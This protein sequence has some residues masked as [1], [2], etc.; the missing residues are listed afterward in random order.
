MGGMA[1][2]TRKGQRRWRRFGITS[3]LMAGYTLIISLAI[4]AVVLESD[5]TITQ[6]L[7]SSLVA[8]LS[9]EA[10]EFATAASTTRP[11]TENLQAFAT[12][13][14]H[15]H[16]YGRVRLVIMVASASGRPASRLSEPGAA[17]LAHLPTVAKWARV[18]PRHTAT[19]TV[20]TSTGA[21][22]VQGG[23][24]VVAGRRVGTYAAAASVD[25]ISANRSEQRA[26]VAVEGLLALLAAIAGGF[27]LLRRAL[28]T[29]TKVTQA[30]DDARRGDLTQRL[31]YEGPDDEVGRLARTVDAMLS[32]LDASFAAQR[33]LL[34][35]VSHQLRTPL[36]VVRGHLDVLAHEH[37]ELDGEIVATI[38]LLSDELSQ[39]SLMVDRLLMLGQALEPD[40]LLEQPIALRELL[41]EIFDAAQVMAPRQWTL[42]PVPDVMIRGDRTKLRWALMNLVDNAVKATDEHGTVHLAVRVGD[43]VVFEVSDNGRGISEHE[44]RLVFDRFRRSPD[45]AYA[46]SG[47]GLAIVKA[48]AEA[49]GGRV[50]LTSAPG[51]GCRVAIALPLSRVVASEVPTKAVTAGVG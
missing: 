44:Q 13:W 24:L 4:A 49:H 51:E 17:W 31:S 7:Q 30:A 45:S 5:R 29:I 37:T 47:L 21:Y 12:D 10:Q 28:R 22:L 23:P 18:P 3:R 34:A 26:L 42:D 15:S 2:V 48:V 43:E 27:L 36:T 20:R 25:A 14:L 39:M 33:R 32:Q 1:E 9:G 38:S 35:D 8:D 19:L 50:A 40:F 16:G 46:G 41:A 6:R 11:A